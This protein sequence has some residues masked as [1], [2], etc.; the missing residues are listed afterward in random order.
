MSPST[1]IHK[2]T[3]VWYSELTKVP[4]TSEIGEILDLLEKL[5]NQELYKKLDNVLNT[6][7]GLLLT[8]LSDELTPQQRQIWLVLAREYPDQSTGIAL[9]RKIGSSEL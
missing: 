1:P 9:A 3:Q 6:I 7:Y 2:K 8:F 5:N 4:T